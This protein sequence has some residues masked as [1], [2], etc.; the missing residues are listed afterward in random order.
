MRDWLTPAAS[1]G[2][3]NEN[4]AARR[5]YLHEQEIFNYTRP[6]AY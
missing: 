6:G 5:G 2:D 3:R 4:E 1:I